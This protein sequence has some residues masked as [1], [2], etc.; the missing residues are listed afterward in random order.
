MRYLRILPRVMR[1]IYVYLNIIFSDIAT[2]ARNEISNKRVCVC[3]CVCT[4]EYFAL[5]YP[6]SNRVSKKIQ[7]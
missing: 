3:T 6:L 4:A 5:Y 2:V 7:F 1:K